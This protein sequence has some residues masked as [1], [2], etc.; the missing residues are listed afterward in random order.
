MR[1]AVL[2]ATMSVVTILLRA[3]P[4]VIFRKKTSPYISYLGKVLPP[5][6]IGLLV[7]Y[8]LKDI[9]LTTRPFGI[10][11]MIAAACVVGVQ[12]WKRN[13]LASILTGTIVYMALIQAVF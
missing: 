10:P 2:I 1:S 6:M 5:A 13:S 8:C 4:F 7:I 9:T 11:E 3:L 12:V